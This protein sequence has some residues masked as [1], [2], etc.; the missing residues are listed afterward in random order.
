M[1]IKRDEEFY[2]FTTANIPPAAFTRNFRDR[3]MRIDPVHSGGRRARLSCC[4]RPPGR[5]IAKE[6]FNLVL[7]VLGFISL[8]LRPKN[9]DLSP[10]KELRALETS[11]FESCPN[12]G[13]PVIELQSSDKRTAAIVH[14]VFLRSRSWTRPLPAFA[15]SPA[16]YLSRSRSSGSLFSLPTTN[17][18]GTSRRSSSTRWFLRGFRAAGEVGSKGKKST[19]H[20]VVDGTGKFYGNR[21]RDRETARTTQHVAIPAVVLFHTRCPM[22]RPRYEICR[23]VIRN[24]N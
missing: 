5:G 18:G 7:P 9:R 8:A 2:H 21:R 24:A 23:I 16:F 10:R 15:I 17:Q 13:Q 20:A 19:G 4:T 14:P 1:N 3:H 6:N 22:L 12:D 11:R